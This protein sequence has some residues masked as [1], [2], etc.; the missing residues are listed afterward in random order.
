MSFEIKGN[1]ES[2]LIVGDATDNHHV[3]FRHPNLLGGLDQNSP[4]AA[5]IRKTL[6]KRLSS[7]NMILV[8]LYF[9]N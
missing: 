7:E 8:G 6:L 1:S 4:Q 5:V 2:A 9:P 3:A